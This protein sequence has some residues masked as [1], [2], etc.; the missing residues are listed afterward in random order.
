MFFPFTDYK[1]IDFSLDANGTNTIYTTTKK[2]MLVV[3]ITSDLS[4]DS[5]NE[6]VRVHC[7]AIYSSDDEPLLFYASD[8]SG[9]WINYVQIVPSGTAVK[10]TRNDE[11]VDGILHVFELPISA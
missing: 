7:D 5:A 1:T 11:S 3:E 8:T 6:W 9:S 10:C 4:W 2:S